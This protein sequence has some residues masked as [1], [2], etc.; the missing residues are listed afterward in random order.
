MTEFEPKKTIEAI[1]SAIRTA[2]RENTPAA[3]ERIQLLTATLSYARFIRIS[4]STDEEVNQYK[5]AKIKEKKDELYQFVKYLDQIQKTYKAKLEYTASLRISTNSSDRDTI[6]NLMKDELREKEL[7]DN[8]C[9]Q[10]QRN[11][12]KIK[13][14]IEY[15]QNCTTKDVREDLK[16]KARATFLTSQLQLD[17]SKILSMEV[18]KDI[19]QKPSGLRSLLSTSEF[20]KSACQQREKL[21]QENVKIEQI[22]PDDLNES[23]KYRLLSDD[24]IRTGKD[25]IF[26]VNDAKRSLQRFIQ[27]LKDFKSNDL[28]YFSDDMLKAIPLSK[29]DITSTIVSRF[30]DLY[31]KELS[32]EYF[33]LRQEYEDKKNWKFVFSEKD[34]GVIKNKIDLVENQIFHNIMN[35]YYNA[36]HKYKQLTGKEI[37]NKSQNTESNQLPNNVINTIIY[38]AQKH[39]EKLVQTEETFYTNYKELENRIS[40]IL[41]Q[42]AV[43]YNQKLSDDNPL[44]KNLIIDQ[45]NET[46]YNENLINKV[47]KMAT[48]E[49]KEAEPRP[50]SYNTVVLT[51]ELFKQIEAMQA[52]KNQTR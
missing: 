50:S 4:A 22:I 40:G 13:N 31:D 9:N 24:N 16:Y 49:A 19:C 23:L 17:E 34:L 51:D 33:R 37:V 1:N 48:E 36:Y 42:A 10:A 26:K 46:S 32:S 5:E 28:Q 18:N 25:D 8:L 29:N 39:I 21:K 27:N 11:I 6:A 38:E 2:E 47:T 41:K 12:T 3:K 44:I 45:L 20:Y 35:W 43:L 15:F 7:Y 14:D 30:K 52:M